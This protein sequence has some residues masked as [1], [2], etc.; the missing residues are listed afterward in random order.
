MTESRTDRL[1]IVVVALGE[2]GEEGVRITNGHQKTSE[3][4]GYVYCHDSGDDFMAVH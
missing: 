2:A 4:D 1:G 3:G